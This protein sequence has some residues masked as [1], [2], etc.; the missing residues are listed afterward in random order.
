[1]GPE[2]IP[3]RRDCGTY[4]FWLSLTSSAASWNSLLG[5]SYSKSSLSKKVTASLD[6]GLANGRGGPLLIY[7]GSVLLLGWTTLYLA[8]LWTSHLSLHLSPL[9][10]KCLGLWHMKHI[11]HLLGLEEEFPLQLELGE[12]CWGIGADLSGS[13]NPMATLLGGRNLVL[14]WP[15]LG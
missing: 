4:L 8:A 12:I 10:Q 6:V 9:A 5:D 1:M 3:A 13:L 11:G 14:W 2:A 15:L 7:P